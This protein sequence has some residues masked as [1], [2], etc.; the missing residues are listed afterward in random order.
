MS[1][2]R[3]FGAVG[4]GVADDTEALAHVLRTGDEVL[5]LSRGIYRITRTLEI[6]LDRVNRTGIDGSLGTA[7]IVM[8]GPGPAFRFIGS[9]GGSAAPGQFQAGNLGTG[10][11]CR[12]STIWRSMA[13]IPRRMESNSPGRWRPH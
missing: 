13:I 6:S 10:N 8:A 1:K 3:E 9:H 5:S 2:A 11:A 12:K 7:T 4:D